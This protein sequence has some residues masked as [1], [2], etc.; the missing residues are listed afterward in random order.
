M[1]DRSPSEF[2][3]SALGASLLIACLAGCG[4]SGGAIGPSQTQGTYAYLASA[5]A[6]GQ[7]AAGAIYQYRVNSDGS[8]TPLST[9][10]IATG[11]GPT[12]IAA[13]PTGR[14]V[15]VANATDGTLS[16]Y[17]VGAQGALN[18]LSPP[19]LEVGGPFPL[20]G[21]SLSID[22]DGSF[23]YAVIRPRDPPGPVGAIAQFSIGSDGTLSPL[24]PAIVSVPGLVA[25]P[26]V[27][28]SKGLHAYLAANGAAGG[29]VFQYSIGADGALAPLAPESVAAAQNSVAV[30][31]HPNGEAAYVLSTC[32][33]AA[34]EGQAA[35]YTIGATGALSSTGTAT[36]IGAH[37]APIGLLID[38]SGSAAYLLA[39][40]MGVDTNTGA[41]YE[42]AVDASGALV[43]DTPPSVGVQSGSVA[44]AIVGAQ[45][46]ALSANAVGMAS[47]SPS[48]GYVTRYA[49]G[50]GGEL[51]EISSISLSA[52]LPT[53]MTFA[54]TH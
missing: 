9:S 36:L 12:S 43:P 16:Q 48:G 39:N 34:C 33:D 37:V 47:G 17:A 54:T 32:I 41:I 7:D 21:Y 40:F 23:L 10:S 30:A 19:V 3:V 25:G 29:M 52:S 42:Y 8:L 44:E 2:D 13:V 45:L 26:L 24:S 22:P 20:A 4:G 31:L 28:D 1:K 38:P 6:Q 5:A 53:S 15:Y 49:F 11:V 14:Y 46:Y 27:V 50:T 18:P 35:L 51:S